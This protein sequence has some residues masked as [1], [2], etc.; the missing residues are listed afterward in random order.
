MRIG[1]VPYLNGKPLVWKL[2]DEPGIELLCEVPSRLST[3]LQRREIVAGLVSVAA[4]FSN[5]N[6]QI[7]PK[8][9]IS[10]VGKAE[11][12]R[13]FYNGSPESIRSVAL[14]KSSL[15]SIVLAKVVL[16]ERYGIKPEFIDMPPTLTEMMQKCDGGVVIGD[17]AMQ[18]YTNVECPSLDLGEEWFALTGLPFVFAVWAVNPGMASSDLSSILLRAKDAGIK[19]IDEI[20]ESESRRLGL[21]M[22]LC[23]TYLCSIMNYDLTDKHIEG[24]HLFREKAIQ[25][26]FIPGC[27]IPEFYR[28]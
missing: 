7:V 3:M 4:C 15:S 16:K 23:Q 18:L 12:V 14:D 9:S 6:L 21:P 24:M 22:K 8:I 13:L 10:C 20:S 25:H 1:S 2:G 28:G 11:S 17:P 26:G 19:C 27:H 5:Q